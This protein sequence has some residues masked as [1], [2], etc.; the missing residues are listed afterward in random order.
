[1]A[2]LAGN[3]TSGDRELLQETVGALKRGREVWAKF[4]STGI[5]PAGWRDPLRAN[6]L[7]WMTQHEPSARDG[8]I[9]LTELAQL[10]APDGLHPNSFLGISSMPSDG[11]WCLRVPSLRALL[12]PGDRALA[13]TVSDVT[14]RVAEIM[15]EL[16]M[17][18]ILLPSMAAA[19]FGDL[20]DQ[21]DPVH[22]GDWQAVSEDVRRLGRDR[23]EQL[24]FSL[25]ATR[26]LVV[27]APKH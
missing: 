24:L 22:G 3:V 26:E 6:V 20:I 11:C 15:T 1:M 25:V 17:P 12:V 27:S 5:V 23:L 9:S 7:T 4:L 16:R 18:G 8:E 14:L 21:L 13:N 10:G 2:L 19:G